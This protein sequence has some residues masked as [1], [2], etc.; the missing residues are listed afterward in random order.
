MA[1]EGEDDDDYD[2]LLCSRFVTAFELDDVD[3]APIELLLHM[4]DAYA[5][6]AG[7][8]LLHPHDLLARALFGGNENQ[9]NDEA[10]MRRDRKRIEFFRCL[11]KARSDLRLLQSP[12][13]G[14]TLLH[15][16]LYQFASLPLIQL[17]ACPPLM[18]YQ[19]SSGRTPLYLACYRSQ[20]GVKEWLLE[21]DPTASA[22]VDNDQQLPLHLACQQDPLDPIVDALIK[23]YPEGLAHRHAKGVTP[24]LGAFW[25][26]EQQVQEHEQHPQ[27]HHR[28]PRRGGKLELLMGWVEQHPESIRAFN[29]SNLETALA[30]AWCIGSTTT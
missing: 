23:A 25:H 20:L 14:I 12:E 27:H 8:L 16:A 24:V 1:A 4:C 22:L 21:L 5:G 9:D 19:D 3:D 6:E 13:S 26:Q 11:L 29:S 7:H 30:C 17:L 15:L 28:R 2:L 10:F 18:S